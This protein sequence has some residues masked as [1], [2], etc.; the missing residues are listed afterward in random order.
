MPGTFLAGETKIRP[1]VYVRAA[2][3]GLPPEAYVP[4]GIVAAVFRASWG[5]LGSAE[6]KT[7]E[8]LEEVARVY[9]TGDRT[10]VP[11]EAFNG[12]AKKVLAW[13]L[14]AADGTLT[15]KNLQDTSGAPVDV[16]RIDA[17]Y[18]GTRNF[19]L[20]V[21]DSLI[22]AAKRELLVYSSDNVLLET[23]TFTKGGAGEVD[24]LVAAVAAQGSDYI[25]ATKLA[26]G[27][28][29]LAAI[30]G[31]AMTA[32]TN[33]TVDAA[34]FSAA[35]TGIEAMD[36]NV[37]VIDTDETA[38]HA[39]VQTYIDRVR[40]AGKRVLAVIGEPTS[41]D[42]ATR[43]ANC[44]AFND[45]AIIYCIN[46]F[47]KSD[48][49]SMEGYKAAARVGGMVASAAVT[50]SLT[51][52]VVSGATNVTGILSNS[53]I[54]LAITKGAL[55]F[56]AN[57][58]GQ[59]QIEYGINTLVTPAA[60]QDAGWKK[61]RRVRTRDNLMDRIALAWD[62]LIGK[63]NNTPDGRAVL[64]AAAQGAINDMIKEGALLEG[65]VIYEDPENLPVGDSAWFVV[66]VDDV[67]SAEKLY[68][69][70]GFRFA[71]TS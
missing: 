15:T 57:T 24:A 14:G 55:V 31:V 69:T 71:P 35:L 36:W 18:V 52:A 21:R 34:A 63:V 17:K 49:T 27:N 67:D 40:G 13:R 38:F 11:S 59:V 2:N 42:F 1:G 61:I 64:I 22:D 62:P 45:P 9:G 39:T 65:G 44:A 47:K 10:E 60:D 30:T 4:S 48:G 20:T 66:A 33:P 32:G 3:F 28:G 37:L 58:A 54:E 51:H 53:D 19:K 16:I 46:G 50:D 26:A 68:I 41:V 43:C 6:V 29:L 70:F 25:T 56:T 8:A 23:F 12:R 5:P 7:L